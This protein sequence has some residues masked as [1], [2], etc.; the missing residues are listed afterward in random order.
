[1]NRLW[2]HRNDRPGD[3]ISMVAIIRSLYSSRMINDQAPMTKQILNPKS[4]I[5]NWLIGVCCALC[6]SAALA[7]P[8]PPPPE[9]RGDAELTGVT[10]VNADR[11]WAVGDR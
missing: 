4:Q 6:A 3:R 1:M 2:W 7:Q 5:P 8:E 11:G 9:M 10:F